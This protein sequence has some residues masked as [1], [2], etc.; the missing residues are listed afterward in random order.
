[1]EDAPGFGVVLAVEAPLD[2]V[3]SGAALAEATVGDGDIA[4]SELCRAAVV[5]VWISAVSRGCDRLSMYNQVVP[6]RRWKSSVLAAS[7]MPR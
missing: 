5:F 2:V 7:A 1:M 6:V 4:S 3:I